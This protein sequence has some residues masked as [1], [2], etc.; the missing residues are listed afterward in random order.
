MI[1]QVYSVGLT[2]SSI[3]RVL[4]FYT[5]LLG[6]R[7]T[8][9]GEVW[10]DGYERLTGVFGARLR[11]ATLHL[12]DARVQLVQFVAPPG[13]RPIPLDSRSNDGW[14]QHIALVVGDMDGAYARARAQHVQHVS[15]APQTLPDTIPNAAGI[16]A[17]YFRDEDGHNLEFIAYPPD[18]GDP[19]WQGGGPVPFG[20]DH[21]AI[22]V[23][24]YRA[25]PR[26]LPRCSGPIG[27][28]RQRELRHRAS[29]P[30][31]G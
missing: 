7:R 27:R 26:L 2:V 22:A 16:Q 6:M 18:K 3:E 13:G 21:T 24:K 17:F 1:T 11:V 30:E 8:H 25:Q 9:E 15:T 23:A 14:F 12:D 10:G 4:V 29:P 5:D 28:G 20:I 31:Y 19:R